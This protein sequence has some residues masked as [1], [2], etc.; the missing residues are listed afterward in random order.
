MDRMWQ[1]LWNRYGARYSWVVYLLAFPLLVPFY[2]FWSFL[3]VAVE[4]S[5]HYVEAAAVT[6]VAILVLAYVIMLPGVGRFR[7][8]EQWAAGQEIDQ[9]R[10]LGA[11]YAFT[12]GR[13]FERWRSTLLA[14]GVVGRCR[15]DRW[16]GWVAAGPVRDPGR[17]RR[18]GSPAGRCPQL[19]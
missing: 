6:V 5:D 19:W 3:V 16:G 10:A 1:W 12:R 8:A 4:K 13:L 7:L 2:L 9:A 18:N 11:T 17:R 14:R 15:C